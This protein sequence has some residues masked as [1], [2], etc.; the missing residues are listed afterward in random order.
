VIV[1]KKLKQELAKKYSFDPD[2]VHLCKLFEEY[3]VLH[4]LRKETQMRAVYYIY[5]IN[6]EIGRRKKVKAELLDY[7]YPEEILNGKVDVEELKRRSEAI[8]YNCENG[9]EEFYSGDKA[10]KIVDKELS[11]S[12]EIVE[13]IT[14]L[15]AS[16]GVATGK[17]KICLSAADAKKMVQGDI[18]VTGMT[19]PNFVPYMKKAAGIVTD[20]GG[21]TSHA[22]IISRELGKPCVIG[23]KVATTKLKDGMLVE[24]DADKGEVK[25]I[26]K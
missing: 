22:A 2:I 8:Y 12:A 21:A 19:T 15:I 18:L 14:G 26:K 3:A 6:D 24:V 16:P 5:R 11:K 23:T 1:A 25:I 20:E 10:I 13:E 17:A 7:C 4:D 9:K